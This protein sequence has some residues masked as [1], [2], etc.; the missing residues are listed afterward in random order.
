MPLAKKPVASSV[1]GLF[2]G[3]KKHIVSRMPKPCFEAVARLEL[4][5]RYI[6]KIRTEK[7]RSAVPP[8]T[9][10]QDGA[11]LFRRKANSRKESEDG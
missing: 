6:P 5:F 7:R 9:G 4:F 10:F 8:G 2:E 1:S 11:F 3:R